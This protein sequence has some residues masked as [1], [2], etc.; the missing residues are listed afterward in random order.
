MT[1]SE[2]DG[3]EEFGPLF[4]KWMDILTSDLVKSQ[5]HNIGCYNDCIT[6]KFHMHLGSSAA[7]APLEF[8]NDCKS[9]NSNL[10]VSSLREI[11]RY[12]DNSFFPQV[13]INECGSIPCLNGGNCTDQVDGFQCT[14]PPGW[15][16]SNCQDLVPSCSESTCLNGG[17][18]FD[19]IGDFICA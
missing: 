6:L 9:L 8:Q 17:T 3:T 11:L 12:I 16:G 2:N 7:A 18:C 10:A 13:D 1:N 19:Q 15:T 14:C 5:G 4:T